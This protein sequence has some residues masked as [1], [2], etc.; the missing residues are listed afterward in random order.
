MHKEKYILADMQIIEFE[1]EDVITTSVG[2]DEPEEEDPSGVPDVS[3]PDDEESTDPIID[4]KYSDDEIE[5]DV[6]E[7]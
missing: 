5:I 6:Y 1:N 3:T 4:F 7:A 2:E